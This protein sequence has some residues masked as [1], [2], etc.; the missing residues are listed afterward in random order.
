MAKYTSDAKLISGA[1][2]AYKDWSNVPGMY[3]GLDKGIKAGMDTVD[4]AVKEY[5]TE[6]KEAK[7][8][9]EAVENAWNATADQVLL[10]AGALGDTIYKSTTEDV[11]ELKEL[12]I[13]GVNEKDDA[14]RMEALRGLQGHSTWVQDHKQMNLDYAAMIAG[15]NPDGSAAPEMSNYFT[16]SEKGRE[17]AHVIDQIMGQKYK[18][19]SRD[20]ETGDVVFHITDIAGNEKLV[21]S[22][23]YNNMVLPKNYAI[24][25]NTEKLQININKSEIVDE[26]AVRQSIRNSLPNNKRDWYAAMYDDVSGKNLKTMLETSKTLDQEILGAIDS[27]VWDLDNDPMSL[28]ATERANFIDAVINPDNPF[29]KLENSKQ[30]ME[31]QLFNGVTGR[32]KKHWDK[33]NSKTLNTLTE[34]QRIAIEKAQEVLQ[35]SQDNIIRVDEARVRI[36]NAILQGNPTSQNSPNRWIKKTKKEDGK[37]FW[38]LDGFR[39]ETST[40]LPTRMIPVDDKNVNQELMTHFMGEYTNKRF[41]YV[42]SEE[43]TNQ[44]EKEGVQER[45]IKLGDIRKK[46]QSKKEGAK[47]IYTTMK[48]HAKVENA[49]KQLK[50]VKAAG[51]SDAVVIYLVD[52]ATI[53]KKQYTENLKSDNPKKVKYEIQLMIGDDID[54]EVSEAKALINKHR[55]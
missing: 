38:M 33:K 15:K 3:A 41:N 8:K 34:T 43:I 27:K 45:L 10:K 42:T 29:F 35:K 31:D 47:T 36:N 46:K 23:E 11:K 52:G 14:K 19:T 44:K 9:S 40:P 5:E 54:L 51:F 49:E 55:P 39:G 6:E 7:A 18:K 2:K 48:R 50:E 32:H 17:E 1:G 13:Q 37:E 53:T 21:P 4:T 16:K 28:N 25:A 20:K 24:T 26:D 22:E 12:Y 30:I